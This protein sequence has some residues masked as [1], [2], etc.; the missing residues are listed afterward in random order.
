MS[1]K[2]KSKNKSKGKDKKRSPVASKTKN[3]KKKQDPWASF[4]ST[5]IYTIIFFWVLFPFYSYQ[6]QLI[7][8][9]RQCKGQTPNDKTQGG[10]GKCYLPHNKKNIPYYPCLNGNL[11]ENSLEGKRCPEE[12]VKGPD[13][14]HMMLHFARSIFRDGYSIL[15]GEAWIKADEQSK[16]AINQLN[17]NNLTSEKP[18]ANKNM[19]GGNPVAGTTQMNINNAKNNA[20]NNTLKSGNDIAMSVMEKTFNVS[21]STIKKHN[22]KSI[23]CSQFTKYGLAEEQMKACAKNKENLFD[24]PPFSWVMP[25]KFGW[26][27]NYIFDDPS[28]KETTAYNPNGTDEEAGINRWIG[29]W[30]AKTQQRSW[31]SSRSIWSNILS[32]FLPYLHEELDSEVVSERIDEFIKNLDDKILEMKNNTEKSKMKTKNLEKLNEIKSNFNNI[33]QSFDKAWKKDN[34]MNKRSGKKV[35]GRDLLLQVLEGSWSKTKTQ[36]YFNKGLAE[37]GNDEDKQN[38]YL[39]FFIASTKPEELRKWHGSSFLWNF[40]KGDYRY[41]FRYLTTLYMPMLIM[42]IVF[43]SIGCGLFLTP[44]S[45]INRYSSFILPLLFG[46]GTTLYNVGTM[47]MS[48][49]YYMLFGAAGDRNSSTKCPYDGGIYQMKRNAKAY[50][51]INLFITLAI[52]CSSLGTALVADGKSWGWIVGSAFPILILLRLVI[53]LAHV[54]WTSL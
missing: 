43:V 8:D 21:A 10:G 17:N 44:F 54:L 37:R 6:L 42:L 39:N 16:K 1:S 38:I 14:F 4:W 9:Q 49:F 26:P 35:N 30:F 12:H 40:I 13:M 3:K 11:P 19:K 24:Y 5:T 20:K 25:N 53:Y 52:I 15:V 29:A 33:R 28:V 23:C 18:I 46:F 50:W 45:S 27:Y 41:W 51:P 22:K 7:F 32:F 34:I 48:A 47:P 2:E 36:N 31:S